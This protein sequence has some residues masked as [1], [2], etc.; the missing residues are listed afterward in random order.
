[1][2]STLA[3]ADDLSVNAQ[4]ALRDL[5]LALTRAKQQLGFQYASWCIRGPSVEANIAL[6]GM[7]QEEIGHAGVLDGLLGEDLDHPVPG[8]DD[9]VSWKKWSASSEVLAMIESWPGMVV[10]CLALDASVSAVLEALKS[11]SYTR[12][13]QRAKKMLQEEQF[14]LTFGI[15][16]VK[17]FAALPAGTRGQIAAL[18]QRAL[19]DAEASLDAAKALSRLDRLGLLAPGAVEARGKFLHGVTQRFNV[20]CG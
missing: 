13:A 12:L 7:S 9:L 1:M 8:K 6:A 17:T 19:A 11:S 3:F 20:A 5:L 10:N 14:H 18:Y 2:S 4:E 15:E 16:T